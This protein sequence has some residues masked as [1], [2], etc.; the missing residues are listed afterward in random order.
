MSS[1]HVVAPASG[2]KF[3]IRHYT[4]LQTL[5][6]YLWRENRGLGSTTFLFLAFL[7][8]YSKN[9]RSFLTDKQFN[10]AI[11]QNHIFILNI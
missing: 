11:T 7:S 10:L 2:A 8:S 5:L 1:R 4:V 9:D 6:L 3:E